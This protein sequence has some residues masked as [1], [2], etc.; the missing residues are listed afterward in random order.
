MAIKALQIT[1][2]KMVNFW[3]KRAS[4]E[5]NSNKQIYSNNNESC[6]SNTK[7]FPSLLTTRKT[8]VASYLI[9]RLIL[10]LPF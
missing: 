7:L 5:L 9:H 6:T 10:V 3:N 4:N 2:S 1:L 8:E